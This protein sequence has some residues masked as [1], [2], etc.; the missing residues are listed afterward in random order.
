MLHPFRRTEKSAR[1]GSTRNPGRHRHRQGI[2]SLPPP[3]SLL[4]KVPGDGAR[5]RCQGFRRSVAVGSLGSLL[6]F[7]F[8]GAPRPSHP[9]S[10]E[11]R[12]LGRPEGAPT[13]RATILPARESMVQYIGRKRTNRAP[14]R[15]GRSLESKDR[16]PDR[17][18]R[19]H[20]QSHSPAAVQ[21]GR[22]PHQKPAC[23]RRPR[24]P[25]AP[26]RG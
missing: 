15:A 13:A 17:L 11:R 16:R 26:F 24:S 1:L 21:Q 2:R 23:A 6:T 7:G 3:G 18:F 19:I 10:G 20:H 8:I 12:G 4:G 9:A 22:C 25:S 14:R 5:N